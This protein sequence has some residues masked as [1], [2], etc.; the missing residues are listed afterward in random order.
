VKLTNLE[1][2]SKWMLV[3]IEQKIYNEIANQDD[4]KSI[5]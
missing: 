5:D 1:N 4:G 3:V 2:N